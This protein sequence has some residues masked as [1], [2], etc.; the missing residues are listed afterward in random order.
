MQKV[1]AGIGIFQMEATH[2]ICINCNDKELELEENR[3]FVNDKLYIEYTPVCKF[4]D[5]CK[6]AYLQSANLSCPVVKE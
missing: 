3:H 1:V 5:I 4:R 2:K 6:K